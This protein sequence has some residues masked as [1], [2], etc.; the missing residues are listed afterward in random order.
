MKTGAFLTLLAFFTSC[1]LMAQN[2]QR[3]DRKP[4]SIEE[5]FEQM[6][7]NEDGMLSKEEVKGPLK[8]DFAKIDTNEDG[9]LS[10][11][12]LEKAKLDWVFRAELH[13]SITDSEAYVVKVQDIDRAAKGDVSR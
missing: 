9:L 10:K 3:G 6:D 2:N 1:Q 11:E 13:E 4:P 12:E 8:K 5:L 7:E